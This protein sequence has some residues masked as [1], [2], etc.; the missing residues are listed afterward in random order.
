MH[1]PNY[2]TS[3]KFLGAVG[4][5]NTI[6]QIIHSGAELVKGVAGHIFQNLF[7]KTAQTEIELMRDQSE[8]LKRRVEIEQQRVHIESQLLVLEE[9]KFLYQQYTDAENV[10]RQEKMLVLQEQRNNLYREEVA[11]KKEFYNSLVGLMQ[12][13]QQE[14]LRVK[15]EELQDKWDIYNLP[16]R[17]R[18]EET[19]AFLQ[20]G[21]GLLILLAPPQIPGD[22]Q[23]FAGHL[24]AEV[25]EALRETINTYYTSVGASH[26]VEFYQIFKRPIEN[27]EAIHARELILRPTLILSSR[28]TDQNVYI[29]VTYPVEQNM[30]R[31]NL[32]SSQL[33]LKTWNW[34]EVV[35]QLEGSGKT[36]REA[37]RVIRE[38]ITIFHILIAAYFSDLY[39]LAFDPLYEPRLFQLIKEFPPRVQEWLRP[40]KHYL[41]QTQIIGKTRL[42]QDIA[43]LSASTGDYDGT[44]YAYR[45]LL[46]LQPTSPSYYY[47][48][49][50]SIYNFIISTESNNETSSLISE[51]LKSFGTVFD[52]QNSQ[53]GLHNYVFAYEFAY[54][55]MEQSY[56]K[57]NQA[58]TSLQKLAHDYFG[59]VITLAKGYPDVDEFAR[60]NNIW[61]LRAELYLASGNYNMAIKWVNYAIIVEPQRADIWLW[62]A[63]T[64]RNLGNTYVGVL[65]LVHAAILKPD[66]WKTKEFKAETASL[67]HEVG[68][69]L[70]E[71]YNRILKSIKKK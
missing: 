65:D 52:A 19:L 49:G 22:I 26:P 59:R 67:S 11:I 61:F 44:I 38:L 4:E 32:S 66:L 35:E 54:L 63:F 68:K 12:Q 69:Q 60:K 70:K 62:K 42:L 18:R 64:E 25:E 57:S 13:H 23:G 39:F 8:F 5:N 9:S 14:L 34:E 10:I 29:T 46:R 1:E 40:Y 33:V 41:E 21:P 17:F 31:R 16:F 50:D 2:H 45:Q 51:G 28:I 36:K 6:I 20:S 30:S 37:I 24:E 55:A 53:V 48:L 7:P 3:S 27:V 56:S 47:Q 15:A 58:K 43:T 71:Y